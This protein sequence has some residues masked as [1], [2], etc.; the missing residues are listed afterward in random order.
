M[1]NINQKQE[2]GHST[3]RSDARTVHRSACTSV[4]VKKVSRRLY[5]WNPD[6]KRGEGKV[7]GPG[8]G[9]E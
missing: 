5:V 7:G 2:T 4:H 8:D 6:E 3:V 9:E 1:K